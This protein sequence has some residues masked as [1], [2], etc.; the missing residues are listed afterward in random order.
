MFEAHQKLKQA[1]TEVRHMAQTFSNVKERLEQEKQRNARL[2]QDVKNYED[3]QRHLEK[4][5]ILQKKRPWLVRGC[6]CQGP[7]ALVGSLSKIM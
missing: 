2:E 4:I 1:R 5:E 3:R 6:L 7:D